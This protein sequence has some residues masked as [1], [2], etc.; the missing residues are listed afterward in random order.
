MKQA[1]ITMMTNGDGYAPGVEA[2]G[3][4][5]AA[6]GT[7]ERRVVMVTAD[8]SLAAR[9][10][11]GAQGWEIREIEP[12]QNPL[13][14][15]QLLFPRF[16][17]VFAKLRAWELT[18]FDKM[19]WLDADTVV[20]HNVDELFTRP[21]ISAAPDFLVPDQFNSGVMVLEPSH[22]TFAR[23]M[24][25]LAATQSYD[26][27]DQG[28]L[29]DFFGD[30]YAGSGDHRLPSGYNIHHFIYQF[31]HGHPTLKHKVE[32]TAKIIHYTVQKPWQ[33]AS[34][35]TGG[36]EVWWNAYHGAHPELDTEWRRR[37]H[38]ME[39]RSFDRVIAAFVG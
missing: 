34:T 12:V 24:D 27:G 10:R 7:R 20:L 37:L 5:L 21:E 1:Y 8:V 36:S 3:R 39:D 28:F 31:M 23:M 4:S 22:A 25:A 33:V 11:L 35:V 14:G 13:S 19:V 17:S 26:G 9:E 30:W 6:T 15:K 2:L 38:S 29:N 18:E 32:K 16:G